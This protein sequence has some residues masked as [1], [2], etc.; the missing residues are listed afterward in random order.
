MRALLRVL[1]WAREPTDS[2]DGDSDRRRERHETPKRGLLRMRCYACAGSGR[3]EMVDDPTRPA[4][5]VRCIACR[6][7]GRV[8][9]D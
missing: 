7:T 1:L 6:G 8:T 4:R 2:D 3:L 9:I 5:Q